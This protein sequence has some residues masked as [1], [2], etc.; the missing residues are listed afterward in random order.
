MAKAFQYYSLLV[1]AL[2][3]KGQYNLF[4]GII[5]KDRKISTWVQCYKAFYGR[6]LRIFIISQSIC[7]LANLSCLVKCLW[8]RPGAYPTLERL[9]GA[10]LRQAPGAKIRKKFYKIQSWSLTNLL[11]TALFFKYLM[12]TA[13][14]TTVA[15]VMKQQTQMIFKSMAAAGKLLSSAF[16]EFWIQNQDFIE[17][18][19]AC[20]IKNFTAIIYG[21]S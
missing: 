21:F 1:V 5:N 4:P 9:K 12:M 6:N 18:P 15:T 13:S 17:T 7:P 11:L 19:G 8:V 3:K 20:T 14:K 2:R 10:S 16:L